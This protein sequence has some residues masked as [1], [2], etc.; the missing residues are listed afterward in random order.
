MSLNFL[1]G[2]SSDLRMLS[3]MILPSS[4]GVQVNSSSTFAPT[5]YPSSSATAMD[6]SWSSHSTMMLD[7]L[8]M[9]KFVESSLHVSLL[10]EHSQFLEFSLLL[11]ETTDSSNLLHFAGFVL[12]QFV[13]EMLDLSLSF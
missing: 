7:Y 4:I 3:D 5:F 1:F 9:L 13:L 12:L 11:D 8:H 2:K 6:A 10:L